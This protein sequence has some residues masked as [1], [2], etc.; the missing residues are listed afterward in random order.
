M[1]ENSAIALALELKAAQ[2]L[3]DDRVARKAAAELGI[4]TT[5]TVGILEKAAAK[6]L[7][8]LP[9][10]MERLLKTNF[11]IDSAV[12]REVLAR[13]VARRKSTE[14]NKTDG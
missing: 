4:L 10:S 9:D 1:G 11:R 6:G 13:D 14:P 5:G 2:L 3:V 8:I 12:V 7:L